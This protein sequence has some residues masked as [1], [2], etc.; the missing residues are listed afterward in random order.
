[1]IDFHLIIQGPIFSISPPDD[2]F[3]GNTKYT[4][5][6]RENIKVLIEKYSKLFSSITLATWKSSQK[7][8][9]LDFQHINTSLPIKTI[10]LND[11]GRGEYI[12][13][14]I[15]DDRLRQYYSVLK[16]LEYTNSKFGDQNISIKVRTDQFLNLEDIVN[17][18]ISRNLLN[19]NKLLFPF[20]LEGQLFSINDYF[21]AGNTKNM[22]EYFNDLVKNVDRPVASKSIHVDWAQKY[23]ALKIKD[24]NNHSSYLPKFTIAGRRTMKGSLIPLPKSHII[25]WIQLLEKYFLLSDPTW[26]GETTVRGKSLDFLGKK[27]FNKDLK[28]YQLIFKKL[29]IYNKRKLVKDN[30]LTNFIFKELNYPKKNSNL[31]KYFYKLN[32]F[33]R[34]F[35][36][37]F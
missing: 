35:L 1:M 17:Q 25:E 29:I 22:L 9:N 4:F 32:Y 14:K 13:G 24:E 12:F 19:S 10:F 7:I 18:I 5:D 31:G 37:S 33:L 27:I 28:E 16:G 23:L 36:L 2:I 8:D 15:P 21:I 20:A 11:I 34:M 6:C 30:F 3:F 26:I